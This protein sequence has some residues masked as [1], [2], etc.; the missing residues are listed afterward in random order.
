MSSTQTWPPQEVIRSRSDL[1]E[2]Y[3]LVASNRKRRVNSDDNEMLARFL[4]L[5][6]CGHIEIIT[7]ECFL[8]FLT[9][10]SSQPVTEYL[11]SS[12]LSWQTP[13]ADNLKKTLNKASSNLCS[14]LADYLKTEFGSTNSK[15][16]EKLSELTRTRGA[17]A[18]GK[19]TPVTAEKSLE[20]YTFTIDFSDWYINFFK[21][22]GQAETLCP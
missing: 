20:L 16:S 12:Y 21:P 22:G 5:R 13:N 3:D 19:N 15:V 14:M 2:L 11:R 7:T 4:I 6:C 18:H 9:R 10:R 17:I 1:D 8:G